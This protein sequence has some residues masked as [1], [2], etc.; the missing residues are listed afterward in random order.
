MTIR[1]RLAHLFVEVNLVPEPLAEGFV[2]EMDDVEVERRLWTYTQAGMELS[3]E[4][5]KSRAEEFCPHFS[6]GDDDG[7]RSALN[8]APG[9][10]QSHARVGLQ[11]WG[12]AGE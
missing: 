7:R 1:E 6:N 12:K 2:S 10:R 5:P 4:S 3:V 8:P 11:K 9:S